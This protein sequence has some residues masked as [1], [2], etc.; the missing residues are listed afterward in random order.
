MRH[1]DKTLVPSK[2][3]RETRELSS[4]KERDSTKS[5]TKPGKLAP[6]SVQ[7]SVTSMC[8]ED[9]TK[10]SSSASNTALKSESFN[11]SKKR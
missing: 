11:Q 1:S 7:K 6:L 8:R 5:P 10:M 9:M 4:L 3:T 2:L